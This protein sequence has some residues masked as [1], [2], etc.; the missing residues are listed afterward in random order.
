MRRRD[1]ITLV[2]G[3]AAARPSAVRAQQPATPVI[4]FLEVRS[5]D[6]LGVRLPAFHQG[7]KETGFVEGDNL[8]ILYRFAENRSDRLAILAA[9]L[10]HRQVAVIATAG[11]PAAFAAKAATPSIPTLFIVVQDPVSIGLVTSLARPGGNLTG[12]NLFTAELT[13]KRLA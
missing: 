10:V 13:A 2:G 9:D 1:F 7:L 6:E 8:S 5:A 11:P 4:G 12:V 3:A